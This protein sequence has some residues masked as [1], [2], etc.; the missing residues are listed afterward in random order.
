MDSDQV[1]VSLR[2]ISI[3]LQDIANVLGNSFKYK[4]ASNTQSLS[5]LNGRIV[6]EYQGRPTI[7]LVAESRKAAYLLDKIQAKSPSGLKLIQTMNSTNGF[8]QASYVLG[9]YQAFMEGFNEV[10]LWVKFSKEFDAALEEELSKK[11]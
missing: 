9:D 1:V 10:F 2:D 7:T 11:T 3:A 6:E 4:I 8:V 5:G